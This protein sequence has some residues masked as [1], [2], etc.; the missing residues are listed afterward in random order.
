MPLTD[1]KLRALKPASKPYRITDGQGL[2][3]E[4]SAAG[5]RLWR[6]KYRFAGKEKRLAFGQWPEVSLKD[7]RTR[8]DEAR[9][10]L[11]A[12]ADPGAARKAE[13]AATEATFEKVAGECLATRQPGWA[14]SHYAKTESRLRRFIFPW[15]GGT[16]VTALAAPQLLEVLRRVEHKSAGEAQRTRTIL[17]Q[18]FD[19]A[20]A[21]GRSTGNPARSLK[22]VLRPTAERHFAAA[23]TPAALREVLLTLDAYRGTPQVEAALRLAPLLVVRPGELRR[24]RWSDVDF[25][26]KEWRFVVSKTQI[27]H[28]VPLARQ[29]IAVLEGL[30]PITGAEPYVFPNG[31]TKNAPMSENAVLAALRRSGLPK[32]E[33]SGH[34]FRASF[35]TLADE[36]L[37]ERVD[38]IEHQLAHKV[39]DPLGRA[40]NR[41]TFL[42]ER[43]EMMQR[44]ADYL[45]TI[46]E[47]VKILR[48][49]KEKA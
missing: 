41:T 38:L 14:A 25:E 28:C 24:M 43:R 37:R 36:V 8:R 27:E 15:L 45:D 10:L 40:Y 17:G 13:R 12:G 6:L 1:A 32:E 11:A 42:A 23:T 22:G 2:Y 26:A 35:R 30:R 9:A 29:A 33:A 20:E 34:G 46:R 16:P 4:V 31:R 19:F 7:A 5:N 39:R 18:I 3:C 48:F 21:S 44:W 49:R 47:G